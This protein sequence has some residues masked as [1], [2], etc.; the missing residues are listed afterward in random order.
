MKLLSG[1]VYIFDYV[2]LLILN[3]TELDF[4]GKPPSLR[5]TLSR[6]AAFIV[7]YSGGYKASRVLTIEIDFIELC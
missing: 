1:F 3:L 4:V 6:W 5:S 2:Y 7:P